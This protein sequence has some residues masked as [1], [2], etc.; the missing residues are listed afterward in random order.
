MLLKLA[1]LSHHLDDEA[2]ARAPAVAAVDAS[3]ITAI[4]NA[5]KLLLFSVPTLHSLLTAFTH[6]CE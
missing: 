3:L 5:I 4:N 2:A 6:V 1:M